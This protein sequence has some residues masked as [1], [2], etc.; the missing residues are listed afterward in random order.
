MYEVTVFMPGGEYETQLFDSPPNVAEEERLLLDFPEGC[1]VD[2][3]R[4][5]PDDLACDSLNFRDEVDYELEPFSLEPFIE[6]LLK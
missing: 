3:G 4:A 1:W 5:P 2:I 6:A